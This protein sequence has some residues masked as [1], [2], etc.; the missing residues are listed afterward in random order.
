MEDINN[1]EKTNDQ[2]KNIIEQL[3]QIDVLKKMEFNFGTEPLINAMGLFT[4]LDA[5]IKIASDGIKLLEKNALSDTLNDMASKGSVLS[6]VLLKAG[7]SIKTLTSCTDV[8]SFA[9]TLCTMATTAFGVAL[10]FLKANPLVAI[11]G[12]IGLAVGALALF[13]SSMEKSKNDT[14]LVAEAQ[15]RKRKELEETTK[16]IKDQ[17]RSTIESAKEQEAQASS[18]R[19]LVENLRGLTDNN[20]FFDSGNIEAVKYYIDEINSQM[21]GTVEL[22]DDGK[23]HW[24]ESEKAIEANIKQLERKAKVEAYYDGYVESLKNESKLRSELTLAQNNY[25]TELEKQEEINKKIDEIMEKSNKGIATYEELALLGDYNKQMN[26][27]KERLSEYS[28]TLDKAKSAYEANKQG[29]DLYNLAIQDLDGSM[30]ASAQLMVEEMLVVGEKG[31]STWS[32]LA[33]AREDCKARMLTASEEEKEEI[34]LANEIINAETVN[35]AMVFGD[36]YEKMIANL[37]EKGAILSKEEEEQLKNSYEMWSMS[38]E[39]I[40]NAQQAGLDTLTLMK[41]VAMSNMNDEDKKKLAENV[42]LFAAA[43]NEDGLKLCQSLAN[44]LSINGNEVNEETKS[45]MN[46][47]DGIIKGKVLKATVTSDTDKDSVD[48]SV[49]TVKKAMNGIGSVFVGIKSLFGFADGGFPDT[50]E[51]FIAREAG[52]ELVGRINGKTAVANNDQIVSG[53]SSGVYN[54]MVSAMSRSHR[55][56]TTVTAIFQVDGKQVAKQVINAHNREVMQTG[57]SP[58]LI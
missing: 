28:S 53:I 42:K 14:D 1:L 7:D 50:G 33:A 57:R 25:N 39:Q 54:A 12:T 44:G 18:I 35:K 32:S 20:G 29:A 22:L 45:L 10:E 56:N 21:P 24:L 8:H 43:G 49:N 34:K 5:G 30:S 51:L 19:G 15:A 31:T 47:M 2:L 11:I 13:C 41:N 16:A 23:V 4:E 40:K 55:A 46:E 3:K 48:K 52:P 27:S 38:T 9:T 26:E 58:L 6:G 36:S 37:K 17:T